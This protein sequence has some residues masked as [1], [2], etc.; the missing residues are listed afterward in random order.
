[1]LARR[2]EA[3]TTNSAPLQDLEPRLRRHDRPAPTLDHYDELRSEA[4]CR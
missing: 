4:G 2:A 3:T 1:V